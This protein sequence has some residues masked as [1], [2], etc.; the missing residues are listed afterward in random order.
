MKLLTTILITG[1]MSIY[2]VQAQTNDKKW[3]EI[4]SLFAD[5][6]YKTA[7]EKLNI[8]YEQSLKKGDDVQLVKSIIYRQ[9]CQQ[10]T[11]ENITV[12]AINT[13]RNDL[14]KTKSNVA[15][16][17]INSLLGEA[18]LN[19]YRQNRWRYH[20]RTDVNDDK[21]NLD[22]TTWSLN[23]IFDECIEAYKRSVENSNALS[24]IKIDYI[25]DILT[26]NKETREYRPTLYDFVAHRAI[27]AFE[28]SELRITKPKDL[29]LPN[30]ENLFT[31]NAND[32]AKI[33][34]T[35]NDSTSNLLLA[36]NILQQL[37]KFHLQQN[38]ALALG[39]INLKRFN[40]LINNS[41][42]QNKKTLI[43]SSLLKIIETGE[44][45]DIWFAANQKLAEMYKENG[46]EA[47]AVKICETVLQ[48]KNISEKQKAAF[49]QYIKHI[50]YPRLGLTVENIDMPMK[51]IK[52]LVK[53]KDVDT[54]YFRIYRVP[55]EYRIVMLSNTDKIQTD[56]EKLIEKNALPVKEWKVNMPQT[57][58]YKL[59]TTEIAC[60]FHPFAQAIFI[61]VASNSPDFFNASEK[62]IECATF[63]LSS[64][65]Y[66]YK[67]VNSTTN[68]IYLAN[69]MTGEPLANASF[70]IANNKMKIKKEY[71]SN[72]QGFIRDAV[73][74]N[75]ND[76]V[77]V[78]EKSDSLVLKNFSIPLTRYSSF[79]FKNYTVTKFFL[80][81]A[82]YRPGQ[83]VYFKGIVL[84]NKD[85][86]YSIA[87]GEEEEI[88]LNDPNDEELATINA[89]SNEY[90]TFSGSFV[91]PQS[92]LGGKFTIESDYGEIGFYV[93]EYKRPTF[94]VIINTVEKNYKFNETVNISGIAKSYAG[95]NIDNAKVSYGITRQI[96]FPYRW[97][98]YAVNATTEIIANGETNTDENGNFNINFFADGSRLENDMQIAVYNISID[99]TDNNGETHTARYGLRM[100]KKPLVIETNIPE[101]ANI[102]DSLL[103][104]MFTKNLNGNPT[105]SD[106]TVNIYKLKQPEKLLRKR[107]WE[108]PDKHVLSYD[109]YKKLFP[110]DAY[111]DEDKIE[112]FEEIALVKTIS[113]NTD[114]TKKIDLGELK[115]YGSASYR[116]DITAKN[117]ENIT[118]H[119]KTYIQ[120]Q[121]DNILTDM[122][123][124]VRKGKQ[125]EK[126]IEFFAGGISD[127]MY[128]HYDVVYRN[129]LI[130]SKN[131]IVGKTP[132][133]IKIAMPA[134]K[135]N[136]EFSV[137]FVSIFN[138]RVYTSQHTVK[139]Y[140]DKN[141]LDISLVT[142]R[143]KLQP[144][145]K[146]QWK[147]RIK[148]P[149]NEKT[150]AEMLVSLYDASLDA[151]VAHD[152][153]KDF[154]KNQPLSYY[155]NNWRET[156]TSG[157]S[158]SKNL[159][160]VYINSHF[161]AK[162]YERLLNADYIKRY[163]N[164]TEI[165]NKITQTEGKI[166]GIVVDDNY[167]PLDYIS[168][169]IKDKPSTETHTDKNGEFEIAAEHGD[170]L[171]FSF[172]GYITQEITVQND[173]LSVVL[174]SDSNMLEETV[175]VA[176]AVT[177]KT[178]L[179][180]RG[181]VAGVQIRR[182]ENI[183]SED[184]AMENDKITIND[185]HIEIDNNNIVVPR[186]NFNETA[187]F[188]P[189]LLT[190][191][192][193]EIIIDF[194]I[195]E[196]LTKWKLL[197][198]AH[199]KQLETGK[200]TAYTLTQKEI[201]VSANAPRFFRNGDNIEFSAKINNITE[202]QIKGK[203]Q[204]LLFDAFTM[205][206][207]N[208][209]ENKTEQN[210]S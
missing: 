124:W 188:Y 115:Q 149:N 199:S 135:N 59:H 143:D 67:N 203:T 51:P 99:V 130:E 18:F 157:L 32:F 34:I 100:S 122:K 6:L 4:N 181:K 47:K 141:N 154:A 5:G 10:Y 30:D 103:F 66:V 95:Y 205:Q 162:N 96:E 200:I 142:F 161:T 29:F 201:A 91:L 70:K 77:T 3:T 129:K 39:D 68:E 144:G 20:N 193:S 140:E 163:A 111:E 148:S 41:T 64:I 106:I 45:N 88:I 178:E 186:T 131:I 57:N 35:D 26:G 82:I 11:E 120:L 75:Y 180:M 125:T 173:V 207:L 89:V 147:L 175:V 63:Q 105:I 208:I 42:L 37:T 46:E 86:K 78:S 128:V 7:I 112:N 83:T 127:T 169:L 160:S 151:F 15:Q 33:Q 123:H 40:F 198:L 2:S 137:L 52:I 98:N 71:A 48:Q 202:N 116:F 14:Q 94:E 195:P 24:K 197:G 165:I 172:L 194:V 126:E 156:N 168:V 76:I 72:S 176:Y 184:F 31:A 209:I 121:S 43:I 174:S 27:S 171:V 167:Q 191:K 97:W 65:A 74:V 152:W 189:Q 192:N 134:T 60:N 92:V 185:E 182:N 12:T 84:N 25:N 21:S 159:Y 107:L 50:K 138:N 146:E 139:P 90:G 187:F 53:Y 28:N 179:A 23:R 110:D 13:L 166:K 155:Y 73:S 132:Q 113:F 16:S 81:R 145:E 114:K 79:D 19:Y 133:S 87:V 170:V 153:N 80:D 58:D 22:V 85:N 177:A 118:T 117:A 210:F 93:E 102:A 150:M 190:D 136:E 109:K 206:P 56:K 108:K 69:R 9:A 54:V 164:Y 49:E 8:I 183:F 104:D 62:V 61:L 44:K 1:F 38:D 17:L 158:Y 119:T 55:D 204:L 196:S 101:T 36:L